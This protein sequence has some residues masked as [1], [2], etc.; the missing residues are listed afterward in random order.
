M[1]YYTNQQITL[2]HVFIR[3]WDL[4]REV[5]AYP[6]STGKLAVYRKDEFFSFLDFTIGSWAGIETQALGP[7]F[8][9]SSLQFCV[10]HLRVGN[11]SRDLRF[12]LDRGLETRCLELHEEQLETWTNSSQVFCDCV[13]HT[14][15]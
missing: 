15:L 12:V 14:L 5:H 1:N 7:F 8:R 6:P 10:E 9:N 2:D 4:V 3:D 13:L 11:I